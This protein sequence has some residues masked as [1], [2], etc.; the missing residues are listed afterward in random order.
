MR[1]IDLLP[2]AGIALVAVLALVWVD[3]LPGGW[4]LRGSLEPHALRERRADEVRI[5]ERLAEF[6]RDNPRVPSGS[7]V[8]LGSSTIERFPLDA[9]FP[10]RP[11][12]RRGI[13]NLA[14]RDLERIVP[15]C[16]PPSKP[17]GIVLYT[18]AVDWRAAR[19]DEE[20]LAVR[21]EGVLD[22]LSRR[23]P[24]VPIALIAVLP[25]R[26]MSPA[27]LA[28]L[29]RANARLERIARERSVA[30]VDATRAPILGQDGLA[31]ALSTDDLHLNAD[32]YRIL[33]AALREQGGEIGRALAP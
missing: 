15:D 26:H 13:G 2:L 9:E 7:I 4:R 30:F 10:G 1:A 29:A 18:G 25:E 24:D 16:L 22:V 11:C 17:A 8:F 19:R 32:G 23:A 33:A 28:A 31:P 6:A 20:I 3:A 14:A 12:V 5:A 27:D 21:V